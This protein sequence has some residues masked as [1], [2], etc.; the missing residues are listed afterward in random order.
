MHINK[1]ALH[2]IPLCHP[3]QF[4]VYLTKSNIFA[5]TTSRKT[6]K[7]SPSNNS[8]FPKDTDVV[9]HQILNLSIHRG[10][11]IETS[12]DITASCVR[13]GAEFDADL[14]AEMSAQA[15]KFDGTNTYVF[16]AIVFGQ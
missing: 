2:K 6:R 7:F 1:D 8:H 3:M 9:Q 14:A 10:S 5:Q 12:G 15:S 4:F 13:E 11:T 16:N